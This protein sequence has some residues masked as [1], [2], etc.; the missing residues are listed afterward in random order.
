MRK[1]A[2]GASPSPSSRLYDSIRMLE[3]FSTNTPKATAAMKV[4]LHTLRDV[5]KDLNEAESE[6]WAAEY[7]AHPERCPKCGDVI[8]FQTGDKRCHAGCCHVGMRK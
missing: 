8:A 7:R 5:L 1:Y 3:H 4:L 2:Q 6:S